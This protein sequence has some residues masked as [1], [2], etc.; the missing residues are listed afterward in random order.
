MA[1]LILH[2]QP[3]LFCVGLKGISAII[4]L[5]ALLGTVV[6]H[7]SGPIAPCRAGPSPMFAGELGSDA[8]G[9]SFFAG[10]LA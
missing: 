7:T 6:A 5:A 4:A 3:I 8:L 1:T 10:P 2:K 9:V